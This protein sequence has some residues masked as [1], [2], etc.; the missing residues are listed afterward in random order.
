MSAADL[1]S[2][3]YASR[4]EISAIEAAIKDA[5]DAHMLQVNDPSLH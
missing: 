3:Q 1:R 2:R 4:N 5:K